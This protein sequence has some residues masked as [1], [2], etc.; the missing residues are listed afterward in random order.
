MS[1][2][3]KIKIKSDKFLNDFDAFRRE[4]EKG[5]RNGPDKAM[6]AAVDKLKVELR[7]LL[8]GNIVQEAQPAPTDKPLLLSS[9]LTK[10]RKE[11]AQHI[12]GVDIDKA[13][14]ARKENG[15]AKIQDDTSNL[16][17][18]KNGFIVALQTNTQSS[19][20]SQHKSNFKK[21]LLEG[22]VIDLDTDKFVKIKA[23]D[24][25]DD[26][27]K[28]GCSS[29]GPGSDKQLATTARRHANLKNVGGGTVRKY[30]SPDQRPVPVTIYQAAS[31]KLLNRGINAGEIIDMVLDGDTYVAK[32]TLQRLNLT[33][34]LDKSIEKIEDYEEG[35][36]LPATLDSQ[37][38]VETLINNLK[39]RKEISDEK[40]VYTLFSRYAEDTRET[41]D[42]LKEIK[43]HIHIWKVTNSEKWFKAILDSVDR[44][45]KRH[46]RI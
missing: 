34:N 20:I 23:E 35:K 33:G 15:M 3:V 31:K 42:F 18:A 14:I 13:L 25:N 36:N 44:A 17:F 5:I 26:D 12:F 38:N 43:T 24:I 39:L 22:M 41:V 45:I 16:F 8:R 1:F 7:T 11:L 9:T 30:G 29:G 4:L 27:I 21:R 32:E 6:S 37:R 46:F 10:S 40:V 2:D 19:T 28:Y